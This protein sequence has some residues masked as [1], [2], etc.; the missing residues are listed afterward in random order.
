MDI[1]KKV[2]HFLQYLLLLGENHCYRYC[3]HGRRK[4]K[5]AVIR[6]ILAGVFLELH[7]QHYLDMLVA[8]KIQRCYYCALIFYHL[9]AFHLLLVQE[10]TKKEKNNNYFTET[11]VI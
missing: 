9:T 7:F 5:V 1:E 6:S 10:V 8:P 4:M 11:E 2:D 3:L